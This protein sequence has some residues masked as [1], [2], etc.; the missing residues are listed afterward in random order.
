[1]RLHRRILDVVSRLVPK[2]LRAEWRAEWDAELHHRESSL[3][4]WKQL[5]GQGRSDLV[6]RSAG[7]LWDALWLRSSHWHSVRLFGR[8]WRLALTAVISLGAGIAAT[9]IGLATANALLLRPPG[10]ADPRSLL[11][12]SVRTPAEAYGPASFDEYTYYRTNTQA[13]S[14]VAA[15][16]HSVSTIT[17]RADDRHEQ[18]IATVVSG[19]YFSV[20]GVRPHLGDLIFR[21]AAAAADDVVVS[22]PF[23]RRLG[24]DPRIVGTTIRLNEHPATVIGV[25]PATFGRML[26]IWEPDVWM[27]FK[28]AERVLGT[29]PRMLT[30]RSERWLHMVGRLKPGV[31]ASQALTDVHLLSSRIEQDYPETDKGRSAILTATTVVPAGDRVWVSLLSGCLFIIVLLILIV[32][33][34]NVTNL[35][36]GLSTSRRHEMLVRA[37]LGASRLQLAVPLLRESSLLSL[38]SGTL[39]Y[40]AAYAALVRLSALQATLIPALTLIPRPSVDLRPDLVVIA[41]TI[42]IVIAAGIAIGMAPAWRAASDGVS[43]AL[44][45]ELSIGEPRK[46]RLR[47]ILVVIQMAV[48][49]LVMVGV[50]VSIQSLKNLERAP[51]GFSARNLVFTGVDL[52]R[53][54]YDQRTGRQF[55]ERIRRRVA[56]LPGIEA[57]TLVDGPPLGNGFGRDSVSAEHDALPP[58]DRGTE[59]RY[60]VVDDRYFSTLGI[61]LLAG[62]TFTTDDRI[63]SP[64]VVVINAT[65]AR[66]HW[67]GQDPVGQR[68][69]LA[70]NRL[71]QVIGV[72]ADGK[73]ENVDEAQLPFLYFAL[74]QH[75]L[76]DIVVIARTHGARPAGDTVA[77]ALLEVD[78]RVV[79]SGLGMMTLDH[80]LTMQLLLPRLI[81]VTVTGFGAV[82]LVLA[83]VG[84]YSTVFYSVSQRRHEMGIRVALG[85]QP[86]DLFMMVL[87]HTGRVASVGAVIG[88]AAGS[89]SLPLVTSL[90]YGIRPVEPMV[91]AAVACASVAIALL[92]AYLAA[93]PWTRMSALDMVRR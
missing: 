18:A 59:T 80:L 53:T 17:V 1:M 36:L 72:V 16:P 60:S 51:L 23:W 62:R 87:R 39:G 8:H 27:G 7:A 91:F 5:D 88:V 45:R 89:A 92:T 93:R 69:R 24:A 47:S 67:G 65:M 38:I 15:F 76:T 20:L 86:R 33:C 43:G 84:L 21:T 58:G 4:R 56:E 68:L 61:D 50:G 52:R 26:F 73:Y 6:R 25:A 28:T 71:V 19:N 41:G 42:G 49:T 37:A 44:T 13:F 22:H 79:F 55:Y 48:A 57:V 2:S 83:I 10:V 34:A 3:R 74:N 78:S 85:A 81:V 64:E 40:V 29:P 14:D 77:R 9:V 11:T 30:D 82:T 54:G 66:H 12:V 63:G 75:Y 31:S 90:F 32:A 46:G 35:L 70:R